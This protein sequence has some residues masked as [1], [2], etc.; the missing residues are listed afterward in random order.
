M[1]PAKH[2]LTVLAQICQNIPTHLVTKLS[3]EHGVDKKARSFTPWSHVV[4]M[5]H[6]QLAHSLSLNDVSDTLRI[7]SGVLTTS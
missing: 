1:K 2:N 6:V 3:R 5:L 7:Y 4:S